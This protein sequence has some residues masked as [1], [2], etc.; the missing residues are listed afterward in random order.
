MLESIT[1]DHE[2]SSTLVVHY[3]LPCLKKHLQDW[4]PKT[5]KQTL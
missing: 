4:K 2:L 1:L 5:G 3:K